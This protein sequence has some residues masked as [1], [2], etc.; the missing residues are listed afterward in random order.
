MGVFKG[1]AFLALAVSMLSLGLPI[2]DTLFAVL[3][4]AAKGQPIMSP[5]RGHLH[6]RLIDKGF[7]QKQAVMILYGMAFCYAGFWLYLLPIRMQKLL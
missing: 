6:H 3:R 4:R 2:F 5:D 1:Y 7:T